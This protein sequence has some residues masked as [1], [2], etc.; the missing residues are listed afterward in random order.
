MDFVIDN[1]GQFFR[2]QEKTDFSIL[3]SHFPR[4]ALGLV[5][6]EVINA[7]N[8]TV[9]VYAVGGDGILFDCLN[10]IAN[11]PNAELA[12]IPYGNSNDFIRAFGEGKAS[13][14]RNV[15]DIIRGKT[16]A[17]D[18]ISFGNNYALNTFTIGLESMSVINMNKLKIKYNNLLKRFSFLY[19]M[20]FFFGGA[21]SFFDQKI[22]NQQYDI[23]IDN[24]DYSGRYTAINVANGPCYGGNKSA[25]PFARPDDGFLDVILFKYVGAIRTLSVLPNYV[26][27][28]TPSNCEVIKAKRIEVYSKDP[29]QIQADGEIFFDTKL[30]V[31]VK[32][33]A[34][35]FVTINDLKY[36]TRGQFKN[37]R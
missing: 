19:N 12:S 34:V 28:K 10:G 30:V 32:P 21:P 2:T 17:T 3:V 29:L 26:N 11:L 37:G 31:E 16:I 36:Q 27:G 20:M 7:G 5:R 33:G 22:L 6:K 9:R 13:M 15:P 25:A 35:N 14:F 1:I 24:V 8:E 4:D 23:F 18:V